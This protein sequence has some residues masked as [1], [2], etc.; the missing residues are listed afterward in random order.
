MSSD[1]LVVEGNENKMVIDKKKS[2]GSTFVCK[3]IVNEKLS[4][5]WLK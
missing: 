1:S 3:K 4:K 2:E 5:V